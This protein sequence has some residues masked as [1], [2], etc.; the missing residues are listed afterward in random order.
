MKKTCWILIALILSLILAGCSGTEPAQPATVGFEWEVRE[1]TAYL[2]GI[3]AVTD[4][5]IVIPAQ[6][7]LIQNDGIWTESTEGGKKYPVVVAGDAFRMCAA[8][9]TVTFHNGVTI[10]N[11]QM[12]GAKFG[13]FMKCGNLTG[14]YNIPDTVTSM[15]GTFMNCTNLVEISNFPASLENLS[16]CFNGCLSLSSVPE[17]PDSVTNMQQCFLGCQKLR[18]VPNFPASLNDLYQAFTGCTALE[19]VPTLPD[20]VTN[21]MQT[22][23]GCTTL[24]EA[25]EIPDSVTS[26]TQCFYDCSSL[27]IVARL[28]SGVTD[29]TECFRN[30]TSLTEVCP[31]PDSVT[32]MTRCFQN[33]SSLVTAP[34][35]PDSVTTM[36]GCFMDC[37]SLEIVERLPANVI[38]LD[39]CFAECASLTTA[40]KI[41]GTAQC[42]SFCFANCKSLTGTVTIPNMTAKYKELQGAMLAGCPNVD[43]LQFETCPFGWENPSADSF[44]GTTAKIVFLYE[45][46]SDGICIHCGRENAVYQ[47]P[48]Y[49][50][51]DGI[52][53]YLQDWFTEVIENEV[54]DFV[55]DRCEQ[56]TFTYDLTRHSDS[57]RAEWAVGLAVSYRYVLIE[58]QSTLWQTE[59]TIYHEFGHCYDYIGESYHALK[60]D[61]GY[62]SSPPARIY[63]SDSREWNELHEKEGATAAG[64]WYGKH[65]STFTEAEQR[66]ETFAM[67]FGK[68]FTNP[69]ALE[70]SCPGM[71]EY[72]DNLLRD[73]IEAEKAEE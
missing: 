15:A 17:I 45:H 38:M 14:V 2:V 63:H 16:N 33:C 36:M 47:E 64:L 20:G 12:H 8:L 34:L 71:Y 26:M 41:P 46:N 19:M 48:A 7:R 49:I 65:Y 31:I 4:P 60:T 37:T 50:I 58:I 28:S 3:G 70:A 52:P 5:D 29:M 55:K 39:M 10:E 73:Q 59:Y 68:Y 54:P 35:L 27:T 66:R 56:I 1:N 24:A 51:F 9:E 67:A 22:F 21:M 62:T 69:N 72:M 13:M 32:D 30:C 11:N 61:W 53:R 6:V 57:E 43:V 40:P 18:T 23:K 25:P 42:L 44:Y